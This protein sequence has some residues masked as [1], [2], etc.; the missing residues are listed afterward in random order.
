MRTNVVKNKCSL[1]AAILELE[2]CVGGE[3]PIEN[4]Y[5]AAFLR[6]RGWDVR[7]VEGEVASRS[8]EDVS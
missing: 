4:S 2:R 5:V 1:H 8:S 3:G 6:A 7:A